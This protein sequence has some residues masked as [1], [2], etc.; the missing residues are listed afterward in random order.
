MAKRPEAF[1]RLL[2]AGEN[3]SRNAYA[4]I[5]VSQ[6]SYPAGHFYGARPHAQITDHQNRFARTLEQ[7]LRDPAARADMK[8]LIESYDQ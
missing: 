1:P 7:V 4:S 2:R 3:A 5:P 6:P 8:A